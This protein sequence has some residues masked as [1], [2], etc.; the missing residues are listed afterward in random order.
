M[1]K[2]QIVLSCNSLYHGVLE[3]TDQLSILLKS[4]NM[5]T[6]FVVVLTLQPFSRTRFQF[7]GPDFGMIMYFV[8]LHHVHPYTLVQTPL[9]S[10]CSA[11][12]AIS[13]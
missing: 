1:F 5:W 4:R 13:R 8:Y 10:L 6:L 2:S 9:Q 12:K 7:H 3:T 11:T